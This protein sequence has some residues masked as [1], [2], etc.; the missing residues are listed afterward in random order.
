M[1]PSHTGF[2]VYASLHGWP[3]VEHGSFTGLDRSYNQGLLVL[4]NH[5]L[6]VQV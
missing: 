5:K 6:L 4:D 1:M 3:K 2:V